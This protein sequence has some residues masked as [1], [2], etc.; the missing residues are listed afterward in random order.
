M[1]RDKNEEDYDVIVV[2]GGPAGCAFVRSLIRFESSLRILLVEKDQFPRDKICGDGLTYQAIPLVREVFPELTLLT[3]SAAFT[4][5]QILWYPQGRH[6]IRER[7]A[8][9]VIPRLE[10]DNALWRAT[11]DAGAETLENTCVTGVL[12]D[13]GRVRGVKLRDA[14]GSRELTCRLLVGA[15]GSRSVVRQ[16][17]GPTDGDYVIYALRQYIRGIPDSTEGLIFI[18]DI[19]HRGYFWIFPFIRD[20]E[21]CA[22]LGYG[23]AT[24]TRILKERFSYYCRTPEVQRYLGAGHF[25][26]TPVG[27]PLNL[28]KFRW[29]GRLS[30]RLWGPGYLLLGDAA[31]LIHPLSGEGIAFSIE[32]GRIAAEVLVDAR[33]PQERKGVFYERQ[34]LRRVRPSFFSITVFCAIRLPMLLPHWLSNAML[35]SAVFIQQRLSLGIRPLSRVRIVRN[36]QLSHSGSMRPLA[37]TGQNAIGLEGGML[38]ILFAA[39]VAFWLL[40]VFNG[41]ALPNPYGVRANLFAG[42]ATAFCLLDA[43]RR[44][45]WWFAFVFFVFAFAS[46]LA[47]ELAGTIT[48]RVFGVYHY[49]AR[50]PGQLFGLVPIIVPVVW[51]IVSYLA[52][53][54]ASILLPARASL[55]VRATI[56]TALLI[57][58]DLVADPNHLYRGGWNYSESGAYYGIPLQNFAA[59]GVFGLVSFLFLGF[60]VER[61]SPIS[62]N[63]DRIPMAV[64]AYAGVILHEGLFALLVAGHQRAAA[65]AFAIAAVVMSGCVWQY[66]WLR[67]AQVNCL[68][69]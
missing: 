24:D 17:T 9:D 19:E 51:F 53:A 58:Y 56:A 30:R 15:D 42:I 49:N 67:R 2:G 48:G 63:E 38:L 37:E 18:L 60:I 52:F 46:S 13:N 29:T 16:E 23:N 62:K 69:E 33:V 3:P 11:I 8:L 61:E 26:G 68:S 34:I 27:F 10:F 32:S 65:I 54:T 20:G 57:G 12:T 6:L 43:R 66:L 50:M 31:S 36:G 14:N 39:L 41:A 55:S 7:Q 5:R 21:R 40:R 44:H 35:T 47:V 45:S 4:S 22:N 64:I 28:A 25:E 59:W 1:D